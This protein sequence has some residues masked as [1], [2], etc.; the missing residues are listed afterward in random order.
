MAFQEIDYGSARRYHVDQEERI[1]SAFHYPYRAR[2]VN[3]DKRYVAFP[4]WPP[5]AHFGKIIS[6]QSVV[7][8]DLRMGAVDLEWGKLTYTYSSESPH[9]RLDYIFFR[10]QLR[11]VSGEGVA[12][13]GTMSDH[14][15]VLA[16]FQLVDGE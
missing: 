11:L 10:D 9:S 8:D 12:A 14:L 7:N 2:A 5:S 16:T 3:W 1:A 6:G 4:Y 13:A 15:P